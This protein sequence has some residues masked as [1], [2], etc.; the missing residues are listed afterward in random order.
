MNPPPQPR[1]S[2]VVAQGRNRVI[3]AAGGLPWHLAGDM[4]HFRRVTLGKPV[5][6]GRKTW[7]SIGRPLPGRANLVVTRDTG[8]Q[9]PGALVH[10]SLGA[11]LAAGRAIALQSGADEVCVIGGAEIYAQTLPLAD[12]L[13]VTDVD[14][15]P[16]GDA[17]FPEI[18]PALWRLMAEERHEPGPQDDHPYVIRRYRSAR[19]NT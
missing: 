17:L 3:G 10:S 16:E 5:V 9:A 1:L 6:M 13:H 4:R 12:R 19:V 18:D 2:L 14:A 7:A 8:F 15:A 11:A